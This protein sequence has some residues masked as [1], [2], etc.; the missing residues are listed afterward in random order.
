MAWLF[1]RT[2]EGKNAATAG[3]RIQGLQNAPKYEIIL[4]AE[5]MDE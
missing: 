3:K 2:E 5:G 4:P 1:S